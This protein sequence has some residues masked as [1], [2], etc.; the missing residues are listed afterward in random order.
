MRLKF[1]SAIAA[2]SLLSTTAFSQEN[3][4]KA[5]DRMMY[6]INPQIA[7]KGPVYNDVADVATKTKYA[8]EIVKLILKEADSKG[9]RYLEAG[10]FQAYYAFLTLGLTVPLHEGLYLQFRTASG[11]GVCIPTTQ[12]GDLVKSA[13]DA[14]YKMFV[15]FFKT[16]DKPFIPN[17]EQIANDKYTQIIRGGD[18]SDLSIMQVSIRWHF[19]DFLANKKYEDVS[20][21]LNYGMWHIMNGFNPVYRNIDSYSCVITSGLFKKKKIDY[22][23]LIR[24]VWA[25]KYNSGNIAQTCRFA[26]PASPYA[27]NDAGFEKNLSKILN[28]NGTITAD[29]V[30]DFKLDQASSDAIK[31]VIS[32]LKNNTNNRAALERLIK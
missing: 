29:L 8:S 5:L 14:T 17:C 30:G 18:G 20:K 27:K 7:Y 31:E 32:N 2:L 26:D 15:Q 4:N 16:P 25:G 21:T 3:R 12:N 1:L 24:G 10:D 28:F 19:D 22:V 9:S 6:T 11:P 13:G 23:K